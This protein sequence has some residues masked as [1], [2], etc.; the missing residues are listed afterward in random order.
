MSQ[1]QKYIYCKRCKV[2]T[3]HFRKGPAHIFHLIMSFLTVGVWLV[4]WL[5]SLVRFGGWR[6]TQCGKG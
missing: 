5:L 1:E 2:H 4:V 6:C 3:V